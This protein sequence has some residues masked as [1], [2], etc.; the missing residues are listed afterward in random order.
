MSTSNIFDQVAQEEAAKVASNQPQTAQPSAQPTAQPS[1]G[2]N[3]F[4]QVAQEDAQKTG[5][6]QPHDPN[7][8]FAVSGVGTISATP[9]PKSFFGRYAQYLENVADDIKY[10]TDRTGVGTVMK[11]LG[12]HGVYN[13]N[14]EKVGD[15]MASLPLGLLRATKGQAELTPEVLGGPKGQT[16]QGVKDLV[17]GGLQAT[18]IPAAFVAPE[19]SALS[20]EGLLSDAAATAAKVTAKATPSLRKVPVWDALKQTIRDVADTTADKSAVAQPSTPSI[21]KTVEELAD[22]VFAKSKEQ[23][24]VL[25]EATGGRVQRFTD[26]LQNIQRQLR[27]LTGT[28]E[29]AAKES[30]LLQ[31]QHETEQSMQEAFED[32]RK[33][34]V[35]PKVV[36]EASA[37][38]KKSQALYD[39]DSNIKKVTTG[40]RPDIGDPEMAAKNPELVNPEKF[41]D[42]VNKLHQSGRLQ[43]AL[44]EEGADNLLNKANEALVQFRKVVRN[45]KI[46]VGA[47]KKVVGGAATALGAGTAYEVGKGLLTH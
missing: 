6:T 28:E 36:D 7:A 22:N 15:F 5:V 44:G 42:R 33:S 26:R 11:A 20:E 2:G 39:L 4:D 8:R 18:Q 23:Y 30:K 32:A 41:F 46:A 29:D 27:D 45:Q 21:V 34:G 40:M 24:R 38:W 3:I 25:D 13:G 12:A 16:W 1:T 31:A 19:E 47:A 37:N 9:Q 43:D 35:D 10:G 14:S 17:G